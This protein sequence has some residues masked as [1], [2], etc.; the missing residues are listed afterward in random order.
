MDDSAVLLVSTRTET[1]EAVRRVVAAT[2]RKVEVVAAT[3]LARRWRRAA[4]VLVG[5]DA[6]AEV[7]RAEPPRR[8]RVY[9]VATGSVAEAVW[10]E[11]VA[12]GAEDVV[13]LPTSDDWLVEQLRSTD[14]FG[15]RAPVV[16]VVGGRGGCGA[17]FLAAALACCSARGG[18]RGRG[19]AEVAALVDLDRLG[20]GIDLL[21]G[22]GDDLGLRWPDLSGV[23]G[24][25]PW[26]SLAQSLPACDGVSVVTFDRTV[27]AQDP[28]PVAVRAV[29]CAAR[30]GCGLV[31]LDLPRSDAAVSAGVLGQLDRVVVVTTADVRGALGARSVVREMRQSVDDVLVAVR[32]PGR[33]GLP[34]AVLEEVAGV[35]TTLDLPELTGADRRVG[36]GRP[37]FGT[38]ASVRRVLEQVLADLEP[39]VVGRA[40]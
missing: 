11:A 9:V 19:S 34:A 28:E 8:P 2:T 16:G 21:L 22:P 27:A 29:V 35:P 30:L 32:R 7:V 18:G 23:R 31:L 38:G 13:V 25:V 12:V 14:A 15:V 1:V 3:D 10:R 17:S 4:L 24:E 39:T 20:G 36:R 33:G 6:L 37:A 40:A 5:V 26:E